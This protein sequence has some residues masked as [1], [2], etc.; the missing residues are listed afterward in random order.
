MK[1]CNLNFY[2]FRSKLLAIQVIFL[3]V[4][5]PSRRSCVLNR[6]NINFSRQR[7]VGM[8][9]KCYHCVFQPQ[10][11]STA[12]VQY[13]R[14]SRSGAYAYKRRA[15]LPGQHNGHATLDTKKPLFSDPLSLKS[16]LNNSLA[17][18]L[19]RLKPNCS[20]AITRALSLVIPA[21][22]KGTIVAG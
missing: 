17:T 16:L 10:R 1:R 7:R 8:S 4:I 21:R 6:H 13:V 18:I 9:Q 14:Y 12:S 11:T 20:K 19:Q 5:Y 3:K 15:C 2:E 22:N